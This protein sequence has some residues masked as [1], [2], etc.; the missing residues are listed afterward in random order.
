MRLYETKYELKTDI[1]KKNKMD[2]YRKKSMNKSIIIYTLLVLLSI[3]SFSC[4]KEW[5][6]TIVEGVLKEFYTDSVFANIEVSVMYEDR[7]IAQKITVA[8]TKTDEEGKF[9]I[10]FYAE[11]DT[12]EWNYF[13]SIKSPPPFILYCDGYDQNCWVE[14]HK[15][16]YLEPTIL[17]G[18]YI[19]LNFINVT[20]YDT[21]DKICFTVSPNYG[22]VE[23][24]YCINGMAGQYG[25]DIRTYANT[26]TI[27]NCE[28]TKNSIT[29]NFSDTVFCKPY[30]M[31]FF[32]INY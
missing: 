16:N 24:P 30:S 3:L 31:N 17:G 7:E 29:T 28:V 4:R 23:C 32:T 1:M 22:S 20:P 9:Y 2:I 15:K 26:S 11:R 27:I 14:L 18:M 12:R 10:K 8:R 25:I 5:R 19:T 6:P 13:I 21:N